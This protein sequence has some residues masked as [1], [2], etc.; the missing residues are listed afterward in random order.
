[1]PVRS[2][3]RKPAVPRLN[4]GDLV[5]ANP[6]APADYRGRRGVISEVTVGGTEFRVEFDDGVRPTTGYLRA[7]WLK[8]SSS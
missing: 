8:L 1:M 5:V 3:V 2:D 7:E 4:E 6:Q